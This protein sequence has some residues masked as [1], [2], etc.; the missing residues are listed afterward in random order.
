MSQAPTYESDSSLPPITTDEEADDSSEPPHTDEEA[1]AA[2][3]WTAEE[4]AQM[5]K[6]SQLEKLHAMQTNARKWK[7]KHEDMIP[8]LLEVLKCIVVELFYEMKQ[9][10]AVKKDHFVFNGRKFDLRLIEPYVYVYWNDNTK[11]FKLKIMFNCYM[12]RAM[13]FNHKY[14]AH[15]ATY[16]QINNCWYKK[17]KKDMIKRMD[18]MKV[19]YC[20][21]VLG[22]LVNVMTGPRPINIQRYKDENV[23][24]DEELKMAY[25]ELKSESLKS[26]KS[27]RRK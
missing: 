13:E 20:F 23:L 5:V 3:D 8:T 10:V 18:M 2:G 17:L 1:P 27:R 26:A 9:F 15:Y 24:L 22:M 25:D 11:G 12:M 21:A 4:I 6:K 14:R 7:K 16:N 19:D